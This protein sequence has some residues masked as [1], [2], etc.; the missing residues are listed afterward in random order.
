MDPHEKFNKLLRY[1]D[2]THPP[3]E[4]VEYKFYVCDG[5]GPGLSIYLHQIVA[6]PMGLITTADIPQSS[7]G[8]RAITFKSGVFATTNRRLAAALTFQPNIVPSPMWYK[9]MNE[10]IDPPVE[11]PL[12]E[13]VITEMVIEEAEEPIIENDSQENEES[14]RKRGRPPKVSDDH[15][16]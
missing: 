14:K 8:V 5:Q 13:E 11:E 16:V 12:A 1:M 9:A 15:S 2:E 7:P 6:I 3:G 10:T 4:V